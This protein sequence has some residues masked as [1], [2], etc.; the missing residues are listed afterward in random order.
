MSEK[1]YKAINATAICS[2]VLGICILSSG[3]V[4]GVLL[5]VNGAR[6][7]KHKSIILL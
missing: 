4:S 1:L 7:L 5:I 3:I 2:L 6:L